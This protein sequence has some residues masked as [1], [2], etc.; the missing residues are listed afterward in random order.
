[1]DTLANGASMYC[2]FLEIGRVFTIPLRTLWTSPSKLLATNYAPYKRILLIAMD[3]VVHNFIKPSV[4]TQ[5]FLGQLGML[6]LVYQIVPLF[7]HDFGFSA[8]FPLK[9]YLV[10]YRKFT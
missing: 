8:Q 10:F 6:A 3:I 1:M 7:L 4:I 2:L 9:L 5:M